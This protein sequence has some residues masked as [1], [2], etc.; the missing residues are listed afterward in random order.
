MR[1]TKHAIGAS[2]ATEPQG[3][4]KGTERKEALTSTPARAVELPGSRDAQVQDR[5][6]RWLLEEELGL[7]RAE[8]V[9]AAAVLFGTKAHPQPRVKS[10]QSCLLTEIIVAR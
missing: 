6:S 10:S 7:D 4:H 2:R 5:A 8:D 1:H 3:K 9:R